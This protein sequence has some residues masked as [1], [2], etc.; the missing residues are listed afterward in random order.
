[1]F[2]KGLNKRRQIFGRINFNHSE[3]LNPEI[4]ATEI[5]QAAGEPE[6]SGHRR[7]QRYRSQ[8]IFAIR[9]TK[10]LL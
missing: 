10:F 6:R 9:A 8:I 2:E 4:A 1:M 7:G 5:L 3:L